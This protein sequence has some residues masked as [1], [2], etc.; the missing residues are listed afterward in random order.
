[1]GIDVLDTVVLCS[2]WA[3][4]AESGLNLTVPVEAVEHG[5]SAGIGQLRPAHIVGTL[6]D[7]GL[8]SAR[9]YMMLATPVQGSCQLAKGF[10]FPLA[11]RN[12]LSG[13]R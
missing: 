6:G 11:D 4:S 9:P 5:I 8:G 12:T 10:T 7:C 2:S 13:S 3:Q 1:M